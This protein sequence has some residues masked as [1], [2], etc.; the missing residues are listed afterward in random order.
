MAGA[1]HDNGIKDCDIVNKYNSKQLVVQ[2]PE[3]TLTE[4]SKKINEHR[5]LYRST[6]YYCFRKKYET[7]SQACKGDFGVLR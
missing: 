1:A 4:F 6:M 3:L 7:L 5:L 2:Q